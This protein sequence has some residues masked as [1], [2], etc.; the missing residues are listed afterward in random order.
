[1]KKPGLEGSEKEGTR[2]LNS[3]GDGLVGS[4][5]CP[6]FFFWKTLPCGRG[7][8]GAE[9]LGVL[10]NAFHAGSVECRQFF[11][12]ENQRTL[13]LFFVFWI[14]GLGQILQHAGA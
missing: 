8:A 6:A 9:G 1:M 4:P 14:F 2:L 3:F 7:S 12:Q 5:E 10:L 13:Q 11:I